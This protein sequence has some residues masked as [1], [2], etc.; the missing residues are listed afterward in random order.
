MLCQLDFFGL[1]WIECGGL[2]EIVHSPA[3]VC[4]QNAA[5][6][7]IDRVVACL[8]AERR[9]F[10]MSEAVTLARANRMDC[11]PGYVTCK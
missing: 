9:G 11:P 3:R 7:C 5:L 2:G 1:G 8:E 6:T 4:P 10:E